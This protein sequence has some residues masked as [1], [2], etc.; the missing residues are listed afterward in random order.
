MSK[1]V[2][3]QQVRVMIDY[4]SQ[5]GVI[6]YIGAKG[7]YTVMYTPGWD[8]DD[9]QKVIVREADIIVNKIINKDQ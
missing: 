2:V 9:R 6:T 5:S 1:L 3:G 4:Q 7:L 8:W